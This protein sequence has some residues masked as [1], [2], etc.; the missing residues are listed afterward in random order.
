MNGSYNLPC[1]FNQ[2]NI[3]LCVRTPI[4]ITCEGHVLFVDDRRDYLGLEDIGYY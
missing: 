3:K 2:S 1:M 4:I